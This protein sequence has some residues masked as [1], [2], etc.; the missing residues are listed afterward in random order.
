M[1]IACAVHLV[2]L[3]TVLLPLRM[4]LP[5]PVLKDFPRFS[6]DFLLFRPF[7]RRNILIGTERLCKA[8]INQ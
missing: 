6:A 4:V 3:V 8:A 5:M 2:L 1:S 7:F